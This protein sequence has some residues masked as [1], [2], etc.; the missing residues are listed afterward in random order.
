MQRR[1]QPILFVLAL[2]FALLSTAI[3][4]APRDQPA[5]KGHPPAVVDRALRNTSSMRVT[6]AELAALRADLIRIKSDFDVRLSALQA[7]L[8]Q[9]EARRTASLIAR[10]TTP[11]TDSAIPS[12][13]QLDAATS[14]PPGPAILV[15]ATD[16]AAASAGGGNA[17]NPDIG[18]NLQ[19][20]YGAFRRAPDI[21]TVGG[22]QLG[23]EPGPGAKGLSLGESELSLS[24]NID[25]LFYGFA[26]LAFNQSEG[27]SSVDVE[28][29]YLQTTALPAGFTIRAGQFFA[30]LGYQNSRHSHAWDFVDQPLAYEAMLGGQFLDAGVRVSW[31]APTDL[32]VEL[33]VEAFRGDRFPASG[34]ARDGVGATNVYARLGG[35][36]SDSSAWQAGIA[37]LASQPRQRHNEDANGQTTEFTGDSNLIAADVLW[38]WAPQGNFNERNLIVQAEWLHRRESGRLNLLSGAAPERGSYQGTQDGWYI[39]SVYQFIPR[40]RIGARYDQLDGNN[41]IAGLSESTVLDADGHVPRRYSAMLDFSNSEFSRF[42]L[43]Y[44]RDATTAHAADEFYVQ[45]IMSLGAHGAHAF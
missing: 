23:G 18:L 11:A 16:S 17:F 15:S 33:G 26:N 20:R 38:K 43:Q 45:Y 3:E 14:S 31:L 28:E 19:G 35:D 12:D 1:D 24:A 22:F 27:Q 32:F 13:P 6:S 7:R 39:E 9:S 41:R 30:N 44:N 29:V 40:W 2:S 5:A 37:W 10:D 25:N 8:D 42:R 36:F 34:A 21:R 4:A